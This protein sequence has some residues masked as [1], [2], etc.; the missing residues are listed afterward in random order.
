MNNKAQHKVMPENEI[1]LAAVEEILGYRFKNR[2]ILQ[3]A[4]THPSVEYDL[5]YFTDY[6]RLEFLGDSIL[7]F[8]IAEEI[9]NLFPNIDEGGLTRI[10]VSLVSGST[11]SNVAKDLGL[12]EKIIFGESESGTC[13]RGMISAL[14]DVYEALVAALYLDG[15]IKPAKA[16]VLST[17]GPLIDEDVASVP[18]NPKSTIQELLQAKGEKPT[19]KLLDQAGPPHN[20]IFRCGIF[21]NNNLLGEGK[22]HSKKEA[23]AAAAAAAL[24]VLK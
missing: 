24:Q 13:G 4:L 7:G 6:Q 14:E 21:V 10:K 2:I 22:G 15:G 9:Y 3:D 12:A 16:F 19:Y 5:E 17:L 18:E 20:R 1:R 8:I 23:Q 11:L